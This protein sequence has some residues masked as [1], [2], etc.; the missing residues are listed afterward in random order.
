MK[1]IFY[2]IDEEWYHYDWYSPV[3]WN[4]IKVMIWYCHKKIRIKFIQNRYFSVIYM[5]LHLFSYTFI[6]IYTS[7]MISH[8]VWMKFS[9]LI[10]NVLWFFTFCFSLI[11]RPRSLV[12]KK[13][14]NFVHKFLS[15]FNV[16][17]KKH[18]FFFSL[19]PRSRRKIYHIFQKPIFGHFLK[20]YLTSNTTAGK[21]FCMCVYVY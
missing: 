13:N 4:I 19:L 15:T 12:T 21:I 10:L 1:H 11:G 20:L 9:F 18:V 2:D 7:N 17:A 14:Q 6:C 16:Y 5:F 8:K 3:F